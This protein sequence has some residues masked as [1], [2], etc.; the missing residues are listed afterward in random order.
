LIYSCNLLN[1]NLLFVQRQGDDNIADDNSTIYSLHDYSTVNSDEL[2]GEAREEL[3]LHD[4]NESAAKPWY[5][6]SKRAQTK[7]TFIHNPTSHALS[8]IPKTILTSDELERSQTNDDECYICDDGGFLICCDFCSKSFHLLCHIPALGKPPR[9]RWKC[10]ECRAVE[11]TKKSR[12]GECHACTRKKCGKCRHCLDTSSHE[13]CVL[14][15]CKAMRY[16]APECL[17]TKRKRQHINE[18][19]EDRGRQSRPLSDKVAK[20]VEAGWKKLRIQ[21]RNSRRTVYVS[22]TREMVFISSDAADEFES[23]RRQYGED[24]VRSWEVYTHL[25]RQSGCPRLV[26]GSNQYDARPSHTQLAVSEMRK[27]PTSS[28]RSMIGLGEKPT[29]KRRKIRKDGRYPLGGITST[30]KKRSQIDMC[31]TSRARPIKNSFP[32]IEDPFSSRAVAATENHI[33]G[34]KKKIVYTK[35]RK[36]G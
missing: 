5:Q 10:C 20:L 7:W 2:M 3:D 9:R 23:L 28:A 12:C 36:V 13:T 17:L 19:K 27:Q 11:R 34:K 6:T 35:M 4:G 24:E 16:A 15:K 22:P 29:P 33:E 18:E 32:G 8:K 21:R 1:T 26:V 25:R 14:R 30:S 31:R